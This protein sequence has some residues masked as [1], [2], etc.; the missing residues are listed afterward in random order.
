MSLGPVMTKA[1]WLSQT[2]LVV[3]GLS[4][5]SKDDVKRWPNSNV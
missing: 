1:D 2:I 3:I 5:T 4:L